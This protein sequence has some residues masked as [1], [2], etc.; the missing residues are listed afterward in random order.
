[1]KQR[2]AISTVGDGRGPEPQDPTCNRFVSGSR[3][4]AKSM[5]IECGWTLTSCVTG[6]PFYN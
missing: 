3:T 6:G 5:E 1:M 4:T 2:D